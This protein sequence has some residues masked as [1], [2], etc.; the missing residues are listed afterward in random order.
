VPRVQKRTLAAPVFSTTSSALAQPQA[1]ECADAWACPGRRCRRRTGPPRH[2]PVRALGCR[3]AGPPDA[4][5][6]ALDGRRRLRVW[7]REEGMRID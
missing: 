4:C 5:E 7:E 2:A 6:W 3:R 1:H